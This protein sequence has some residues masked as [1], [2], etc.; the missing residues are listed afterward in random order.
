MIPIQK[1]IQKVAEDCDKI[2][3]YLRINRKNLT[4]DE[5]V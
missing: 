2:Y 4:R 3:A 1:L 5:Q